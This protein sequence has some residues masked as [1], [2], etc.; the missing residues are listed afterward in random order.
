MEADART[1][2]GLIGTVDSRTTSGLI[3]RIR[4]IFYGRGI[5]W[6]ALNSEYD[7]AKALNLS[8][9]ITV[10]VSNNLPISRRIL[11][12]VSA[13]LAMSRRIWGN[14]SASLGLSRNIWGNIAASLP[15]SRMIYD[16]LSGKVSYTFKAAKRVREYFGGGDVN[17]DKKKS[18]MR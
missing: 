12:S 9:Y 2:R 4:Q 16:N 18:R 11:G 1:T 6:Y 8:R 5:S 3:L 7:V 15:V 17:N 10:S 14:I 13:S